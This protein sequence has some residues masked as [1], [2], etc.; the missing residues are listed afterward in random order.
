MVFRPSPHPQALPPQCRLP[1]L[2]FEFDLSTLP[3]AAPEVISTKEAD[4][5]A[6][7]FLMTQ[8][9][10]EVMFWGHKKW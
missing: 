10:F 9:H 6:A 1:G 2:L 8:G 5:V 4:L 7:D 3:E